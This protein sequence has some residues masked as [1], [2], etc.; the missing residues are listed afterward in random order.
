[1]VVAFLVPDIPAEIKDQLYREK[2]LAKYAEYEEERKKRKIQ[3]Q[4]EELNF[5]SAP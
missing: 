3:E 5:Q 4:E 1:M 2:Y